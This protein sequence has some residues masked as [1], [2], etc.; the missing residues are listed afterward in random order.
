MSYRNGL[1]GYD[2]GRYKSGFN[3]EEVGYLHIWNP[4]GNVIASF[5]PTPENY[6]AC[7][8]I[9]DELNQIRKNPY[10]HGGCGEPGK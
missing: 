8:K 9:V 5:D 6:M 1:E 2:C 3:K 4:E 7:T 10:G